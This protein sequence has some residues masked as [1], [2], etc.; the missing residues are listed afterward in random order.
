MR[1]NQLPKYRKYLV[2][3]LIPI[4]IMSSFVAH[5]ANELSDGKS[6]AEL[7]SIVDKKL[8]GKTVAWVP[9]TLG[10]PLTDMWTSVMQDEANQMGLKLIVRDP[11]F[12]TTA[13]LDA[14]TALVASKPDVL[15]VHNFNVQL[16]AK[17]L[18]AAE[19]AG[20]YVVQVNMVSNYKTDGYVGADWDQVG[21]MV[22]A[23]VVQACGKGSNTSGEV[24]VIQGQ[25]TS[26][27]SIEQLNAFMSVVSK[28]PTIK[29]VSNQ[30]G[31]WDASTANNITTTVLQQHPN[32]CATFGFWGTMQNGAAQA[33][34]AAGKVGK[35]KVYAS[36]EGSRQDC[37][38]VQDGLFTKF[39]NYNGA[40]QGRAI[41]QMASQLLQSG[42]KPGA[43]RTAVYSKPSW[44]TKENY[45]PSVCFD[46][47]KK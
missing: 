7:K 16:L 29:V 46:V 32:L 28:D 20:I 23:E 10:F 9:T 47:P 39:L 30:A 12:N 36:G 1:F 3:S 13:Q 18:Q 34:K 45:D 4:A 2:K 40:N 6:S 11:A 41:M 8:N 22:G 17:Q 37:L 35:V 15:V 31:N 21:R 24:A 19:K 44:I 5:A 26:A 38:N 33:V 25:L 14:V 43:V 42:Q 27:A